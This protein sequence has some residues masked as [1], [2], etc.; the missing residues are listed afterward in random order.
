EVFDVDTAAP[1]VVGLEVAVMHPLGA[2]EDVGTPK[3]DVPFRVPIPFRAWCRRFLLN[4]FGFFAR[5][6]GRS[7]AI[8]DADHRRQGT[9]H[10][11]TLLHVSPFSFPRRY[12]E[13]Y[14]AVVNKGETQQWLC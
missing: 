2:G 8:S 3:T 7:S 1:G 4:L 13:R 6:V 12:R 11:S 14:R 5:V 9:N 10:S